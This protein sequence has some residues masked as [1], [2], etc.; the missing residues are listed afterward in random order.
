M[1]QMLQDV[2]LA[3]MNQAPI[4]F[5]GRA[6]GMIFEVKEIVDQV[7]LHLGGQ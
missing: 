2:K 4:H 6:G 1:G 3:V 7:M 5:Y